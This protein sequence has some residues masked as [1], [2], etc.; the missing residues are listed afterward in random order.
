MQSL[1]RPVVMKRELSLKAK[2]SIYQ[3]IYVTTLTCGH[4]LWVMTNRMR[5][6]V[7]EAEMNE[8]GLG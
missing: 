3:S 6:R 8:E 7:Q 1:H 4:E 2:L 5:L